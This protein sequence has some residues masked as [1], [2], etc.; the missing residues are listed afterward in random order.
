M[1]AAR[2]FGVKGVD[3]A[4]LEGGD[5][6]L[7]KTALVQRIGVDRDRDVELLGHGETAIDRRRGRSPILVQFE[8]ARAGLDH[9]DERLRLRSVAFAEEAEID[10]NSLG[11]LQHARELPRPR[12]AGRRGRPRRRPGAAAEHR[13][14]AAIERLFAQLRTDQMNMA[15]DAAGRDDLAL[16]GDDLGPGTDN[17]IDAG[18]DVGVARLADAGDAPVA[19]ANIGFDDAPMIQ[20][21]GIRDNRVDRALGARAL[22]LPHAVADDL[23][24]A[25]LDLLAIDRAVAF[26]L[27]DQFGIGE[28][29]AIA[30]CRTKHR[31]I[32]SATDR[33]RHLRGSR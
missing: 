25:E 8:P 6:I 4:A 2:A 28:A 13:R 9:L 18:L 23:A 19:N 20:D 22:P 10:R 17:D 3:V 5:R 24:A 21:D 26:D 11:G 29:N 32:T 1:A 30:D 12:R 15:V 14:D 7:D 16:A 33:A 31:G 27:D